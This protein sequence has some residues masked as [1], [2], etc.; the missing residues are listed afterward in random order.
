MTATISYAI[1]ALVGVFAAFGGLLGLIRGIRR[2]TIRFATIIASIAISF[3]ICNQIY[4]TMIS[5]IEGYNLAEIIIG[6]GVA[7]DEAYINLLACV[8]ATLAGYILA[9]PLGLVILPIAFVA[10]FFVVSA[11]MIIIHKILSGILG[12]TRKNNNGFTRF[13]GMI[14]GIIQGAIVAAVFL[15][16]VVSLMDTASGAVAEVKEK[17]PDNETA[18]ALSSVYDEYLSE[19]ESNVAVIAVKNGGRFIYGSFATVGIEGEDTDITEVVSTALEIYV[20][21]TDI[22]QAD[23]AALREEE[24]VAITNIINAVTENQYTTVVLSEALSSLGKA[25]ESGAIVFNYEEPILSLMNSLVSVIAT[26]DKTNLATDVNTAKDMYFLLSDAGVLAAAA[27]NPESLLDKFLECNDEGDSLLSAL[28]D[29]VSE[30]PRMQPLVNQMSTVAVSMLMNNSE[31][32]KETAE[33][34]ESV[35]GGLVDALSIDKNAYATEDEYKAAVSD[36]IGAALAENGIE[37]T[38][39]NLS[40]VSD[41]VLDEFEGKTEIT[42]ADLAEFMAKYYDV[43]KDEIDSLPIE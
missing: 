21:Y 29:T 36:T 22:A 37:L 17:Y 1:Y 38:D 11:V 6:S 3:I 40:Q 41:F 39:D 5:E 32:D 31:I 14:A 2:Q 26:S 28:L 34:I 13:L 18:I 25:F 9:L 43:Y 12:F 7:L 33:V 27:E 19:A 15:I 35:K 8:D 23:F 4:P 30:N 16:P 10:V 42:D 20:N 24:K